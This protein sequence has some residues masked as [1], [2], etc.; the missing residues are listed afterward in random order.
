[1]PTVEIEIN[2]NG[3]PAKALPE[4]LQTWLNTKINEASGKGAEKAAKEAQAQ[5]EAEVRKARDEERAL[6]SKT[7]GDPAATEK[8]KNLEVELSK[9]KEE[10]AIRAKNFEEAQRL[11]DERHA[12][13]LA[14]REKKYGEEIGLTKAEIEKRELRLRQNIGTDIKS[15]A[16]K[17]GARDASLSEMGK[18]LKDYVDLD[19]DLNPVVLADAFKKEFTDSKLGEDGKPVS[20][21]GLVAEY[22]SLHPHHKAPVKGVGGGA[23]GGAS[24]SG[25]VTKTKDAERDAALEAVA[26]RPDIA[27]SAAFIGR[28]RNRAAS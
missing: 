20:I 28:I 8:L 24:I 22:L 27:T 14:E 1:M 2:D 9:L 17:A 21:E 16:I 26:E 12:K 23:R 13:E 11:R 19:G 6:A 10:E 25:S 3:S 4:S 18:L 5:L 7:G 15:E